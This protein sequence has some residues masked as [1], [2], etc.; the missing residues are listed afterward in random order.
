[1]ADESGISLQYQSDFKHAEMNGDAQALRQVILNLCSNAIRHSTEGGAVIISL[2]HADNKV[3]VEVS[4]TGAGIAPEHVPHI[5]EAGFSASGRTSGLGLAVCKRI[6]EA[7][8][9]TLGV[10]CSSNHG[11]T[12][13]LEIPSV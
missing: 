10:L 5:F 11:T 13:Y 4:D 12:M 9:G 1:V 6:V 3:R 8:R 7:H 2:T